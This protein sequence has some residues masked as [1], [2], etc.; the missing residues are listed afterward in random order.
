[1]GLSRYKDDVPLV[2]VDTV[3]TFLVVVLVF[4]RVYVRI[5]LV[6]SFRIDDCKFSRIKFVVKRRVHIY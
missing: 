3:L 6:K 2:A 4:A 1:M 5:R